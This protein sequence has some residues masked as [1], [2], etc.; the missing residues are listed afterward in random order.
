MLKTLLMTLARREALR[1]G[2]VIARW[3]AFFLLE[4]FGRGLF[5]LSLGCGQLADAVRPAAD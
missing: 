3:G 5:L 1:R 4:A 2:V